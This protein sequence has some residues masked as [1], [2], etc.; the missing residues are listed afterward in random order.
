MESETVRC[1]RLVVTLREQYNYWNETYAKGLP[2]GANVVLDAAA[3]IE[4]LTRELDNAADALERKDVALR[5]ARK[6]ILMLS[7][8]PDGVLGMQALHAVKSIDVALATI[9][10]AN[11]TDNG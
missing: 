2:D 6:A 5:E 3:E 7:P 8:N 4:R 9:P 10:Q 1:A 11:E